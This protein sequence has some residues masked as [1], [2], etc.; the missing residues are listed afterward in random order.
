MGE[1]FYLIDYYQNMATFSDQNKR[2]SCAFWLTLYTEHM[3]AYKGTLHSLQC[4]VSTWT[5]LIFGINRII[6]KSSY[7][8]HYQYCRDNCVSNGAVIRKQQLLMV[9]AHFFPYM[10]S[11]AFCTARLRSAHIQRVCIS[12][13][14]PPRFLEPWTLLPQFDFSYSF[15]WLTCTWGLNSH[16]LG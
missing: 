7:A 6:N 12:P 8:C 11:R 9:S 15:D 4:P 13:Y 16:R 10:F 14:G 1:G 2:V 3:K 5:V